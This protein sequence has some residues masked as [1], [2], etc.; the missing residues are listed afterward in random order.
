MR[1]FFCLV[2]H[3]TSIRT[4]CYERLHNFVK[5]PRSDFLLVSAPAAE[6]TLLENQYCVCMAE[7][8][9]QKFRVGDPGRFEVMQLMS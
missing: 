1:A 6:F 7:Y 9:E 5:E 3:L 2:L 8:D 4:Y